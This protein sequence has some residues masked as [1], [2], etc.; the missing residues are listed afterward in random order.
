M[1]V[2]SYE[3]AFS[4]SIEEDRIVSVRSYACDQGTEVGKKVSAMDDLAVLEYGR[5]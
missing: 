2:L 3:L 4:R 5:S 1:E